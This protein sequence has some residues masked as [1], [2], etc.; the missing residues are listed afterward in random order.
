MTITSPA[1]QA[2]YAQ[3]L[4]QGNPAP[5]AQPMAPG[6]EVSPAAAMNSGMQPLLQA[7]MQRRLMAQQQAAGAPPAPGGQQQ[8]MPQPGMPWQADPNAM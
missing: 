1:Q 3:M 7:L 2:I 8:T 5:A 6:A 4:T